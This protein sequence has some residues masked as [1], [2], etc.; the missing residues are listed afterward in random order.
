M[1]LLGETQKK[2]PADVQT[3]SHHP[4]GTVHTGFM[5]QLN[6]DDRRITHNTPGAC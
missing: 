3:W 2:H 1:L 5:L 6:H 4:K